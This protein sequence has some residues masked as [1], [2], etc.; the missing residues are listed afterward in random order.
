[1]SAKAT[2]RQQFRARRLALLPQSPPL[3]WDALMYDPIYRR[4]LDLLP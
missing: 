4:A 3:D 2:L 1:M